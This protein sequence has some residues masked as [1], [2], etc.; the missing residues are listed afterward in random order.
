MQSAYAN[1]LGAHLVCKT[2]EEYLTILG[3]KRCHVLELDVSQTCRQLQDNQ[4]ARL[5]CSIGLFVHCN[6][7]DAGRPATTVLLITTLAT[8]SGTC[9][10]TE[11]RALAPFRQ[12]CRIQRTYWTGM[13][14]PAVLLEFVHTSLQ[15]DRRHKKPR[16]PQAV[17]KKARHTSCT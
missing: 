11:T 17:H 1:I 5:G 10:C 6:T 9:I 12:L 14:P 2:T 13:Q 15:T 7:A 4:H 8:G 3:Q 16:H